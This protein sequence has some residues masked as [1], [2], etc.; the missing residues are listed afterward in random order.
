[1]KIRYLNFLKDENCKQKN[2]FILYSKKY[3]DDY[4]RH[5][6]VRKIIYIQMSLQLQTTQKVSR[7][8]LSRFQVLIC[9]ET[10]DVYLYFLASNNRI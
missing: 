5:F 7:I 2:V 9:H 6:Y 4:F 1:M 8:V 10:I 3:Y